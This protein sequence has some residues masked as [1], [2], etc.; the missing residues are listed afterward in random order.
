MYQG[1]R[2]SFDKINKTFGIKL[3]MKL[4]I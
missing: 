2:R 1:D 4:F 3:F